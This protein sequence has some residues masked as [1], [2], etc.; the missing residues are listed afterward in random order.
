VLEAVDEPD[1]TEDDVEDSLAAISESSFLA[2]SDAFFSDDSRSALVIFLM[3]KER[4]FS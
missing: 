2:S 4:S 1:A 3:E